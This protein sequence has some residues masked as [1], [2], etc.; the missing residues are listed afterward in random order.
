MERFRVSCAEFDAEQDRLQGLG[1]SSVTTRLPLVVG[2]LVTAP[3]PVNVGAQAAP[4]AVHAPAS[5]IPWRGLVSD[6]ALV[7]VLNEL[8]PR[9]ALPLQTEYISQIVR[10]N[11]RSHFNVDKY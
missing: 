3:A 11:G 9:G 8:M 4:P 1:W 6:E 10:R 7:T 2:S 5:R